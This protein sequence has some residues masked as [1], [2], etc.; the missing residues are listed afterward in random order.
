MRKKELVKVIRNEY[1]ARHVHLSSGED[2]YDTGCTLSVAGWRWYITIRLPQ[3]VLQPEREKVLAAGWD[4]ATVE[5]MG[6]DWYWNIHERVYGISLNEN[7][8]NL[9]LG[10]QT[11]D[12]STEQRWGC[13]LPWSEW[14][15]TK[16]TLCDRA[17]EPWWSQTERDEARIRA[18]G[19]SSF[20]SFYIARRALPKRRFLF[21]DFDGQVIHAATFVE[22][23]ER[24]LGTGWFKW[25]GLIAPMRQHR[26]LEIEF[27][28]EVGPGKG[29][30]KGGTLGH[31]IEL[32]PNELHESGFRRYCFIHDLKFH[33][34]I[35]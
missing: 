29:S 17:G 9:S 11:M 14:R 21:Q 5:R 19:K 4:A 18:S 26:S 22:L 6:R 16:H 27:S 10:R 31:G 24:R 3:W 20:D 34:E 28:R 32:H 13:F 8:L 7:H 15:Q 30:W 1:H 35:E 23:R 12:S 25:L 2:H 33:G